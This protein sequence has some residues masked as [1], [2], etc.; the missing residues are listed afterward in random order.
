MPHRVVAVLSGLLLILVL[1]ACG[2]DPGD[3]GNGESDTGAEGVGQKGPFQAGGQA[4]AT[5]LEDDGSYGADTATGSIG[6]DGSYDLPGLHWTGPSEI[7]LSGTYFDEVNATFSGDSRE[8]RAVVDLAGDDTSANVNLYTH[9]AAARTRHLVGEGETF[10]DGRDQAYQELRGLTGIVSDPDELDLLEA[11]N[12]PEDDGAN[13]LLFSAALLQAGHGQAEI[14]AIAADFADD[15][16]VNGS[17]TGSGDGE[18]AWQDVQ[19]AAAAD[20]DLLTTARDNL[21]AEYGATPPDA[22]SGGIG[23]LL[24]P[25]EAALLSEPR[26]VCEDEPFDG[27]GFDDNDEF[28]VFVPEA[29]GHYTVELYPDVSVAD[30]NAGHCSYTIHTE[31]DPAS[32]DMGSRYDW[33]GVEGLSTGRLTAGEKYYILVEVSKDDD[34]GPHPRFVLSATRVSEGKGFPNGAHEIGG[35]THDG[36]VGKLISHSTESFYK[37][38]AGT[39][40][41]TISVGNYPCAGDGSLRLD[42]YEDDFSGSSMAKSWESNVCGH[43]LEAGLDPLRTYYLK[44]TNTLTNQTSSFAP[45]PGRITFDLTISND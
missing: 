18:S 1:T 44:V 5:A 17:A 19:D 9:F 35:G 33:C 41:H 24:D 45:E 12:G 30:P 8:L 23:W 32:S 22:G 39:G 13:L 20:P 14:D 40:N 3:T 25:C 31:D 36:V 6:S 26:V 29:N 21:Q 11:T 2:G 15:G 37:F 42:L 28:V 10:A 4:V 16:E 34:L 27:D 38:T 43:S 7:E